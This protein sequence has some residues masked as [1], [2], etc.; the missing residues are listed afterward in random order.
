MKNMLKDFVFAFLLCAGCIC[1]GYFAGL[2]QIRT[3]SKE[4][5]RDTVTIEKWIHDTLPSEHIVEYIYKVRTDTARLATVDTVFAGDSASVEV[6]IQQKVYRDS[7]Y[8]AHVSGYNPSLDSIWVKYTQRLVTDITVIR[9]PAK[10]K[11]W[12]FGITAGPGVIMN[13]TGV[14]FGGGVALGVTYRF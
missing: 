13:N 12:G 4:V 5:Y 8:V 14:H 7:N 2:R 3:Y 1:I 6:P 10:I 9:E 11:H